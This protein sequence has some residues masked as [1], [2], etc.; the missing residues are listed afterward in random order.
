MKAHFSYR[1]HLQGLGQSL[2]TQHTVDTLAAEYHDA[3]RE[4]P[5]QSC[6]L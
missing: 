1:V 3:H 5:P 6:K 4:N 2:P